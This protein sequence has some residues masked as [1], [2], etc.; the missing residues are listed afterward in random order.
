MGRERLGNAG[1]NVITGPGLLNLDF[2]M[3]KNTA[4]PSISETFRVQFRAEVFNILNHTNF[5]TPTAASAQ[6]FGLS[7]KGAAA[8]LNPIPSAGFL[9]STSTTSRQIQLALKVS[10]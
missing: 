10:F 5:S 4:L 7:G 9:N 6:L 3:V 1:R 8:V 2:S